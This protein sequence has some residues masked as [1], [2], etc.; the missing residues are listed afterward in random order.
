MGGIPPLGYD[1]ADRRLVIN[2][3]EAELIQYIFKRFTE[4]ASTTLLYKELKLKAATSKSWTTQ[5]GRHRPGKAI[6]RGLIYKLLNNRNYLGEL[7]HKDQWY[8]GKHEVII[9]KKLWDDVHSILALHFRTRGNYSRGTIPFLLKGIIFGEDG[10][11]LT[12]WTSAKKKSGRR[13]RY[14]ISTRDTKEYSGASGLP[15]IP[16]AELESMVV[17]QIRILLNTPPIRKRIATETSKQEEAMDEAQ[18]AVALKQI[19]KIWDQLFP[20]EQGRIIR[21]LV[22]KVVISPDNV[23]IRLRDNGVERLALEITH[24]LFTHKRM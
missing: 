15:R 16:A 21:L 8:E 1:V 3:Q 20:E 6:D 23:D 5:D 9:D 24:S 18:V 13:Y 22:E 12:C 2:P 10:R 19:D 14:Y 17:E 11:A 4:L 7:R